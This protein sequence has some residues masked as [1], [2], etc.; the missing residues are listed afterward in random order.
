MRAPAYPMPVTR[1]PFALQTGQLARRN[2]LSGAS[3]RQTCRLVRPADPLHTN[4]VLVAQ[5][6]DCPVRKTE[7]VHPMTSPSPWTRPC[8]PYRIEG[9]GSDGGRVSG[10]S[11]V[12]VSAM[13]NQRDQLMKI[14]TCTVNFAPPQRPRP[15]SLPLPPPHSG[16]SIAIPIAPRAYLHLAPAICNE[17][18]TQ[19]TSEC[20]RVPVDVRASP[21]SGCRATRRAAGHARSARV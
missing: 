15:P 10:G 12:A 17:L 20:I 11:H 19:D 7:T 14:T 16:R 13:G 6:Y 5:V 1:R 2:Y 18:V 8:D 21:R 3:S 4:T 9:S